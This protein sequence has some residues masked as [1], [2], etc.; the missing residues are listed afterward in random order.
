MKVWYLLAFRGT[1]TLSEE[2]TLIATDKRGYPHNITPRK[3]MSWYSLEAPRW[4]AFNEYPQHIF[5]WNNKKY[6]S[7]FRMKKGP[8]LLLWTLS[9]VLAS[10]PKKLVHSKRK[11]SAPKFFPFRVDPFYSSGFVCRRPNRKSHKLSHLLI[12]VENLPD[13][14]S[15]LKRR[16]P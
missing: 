6:I 2:T 12:L 10:L 7:I 1:A 8:Y 5:S 3:H 9:N 14:A 13:V 15:S 11:G 4:D 16:P